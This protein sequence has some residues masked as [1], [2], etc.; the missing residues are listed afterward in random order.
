MQSFIVLFQCMAVIFYLLSNGLLTA[1]RIHDKIWIISLLPP[2]VRKI[3]VPGKKSSWP[4]LDH[5]PIQDKDTQSTGYKDC[6]SLS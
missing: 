6:L 4:G 2:P 3:K 5:M 1:K